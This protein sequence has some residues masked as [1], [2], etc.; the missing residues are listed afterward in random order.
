MLRHDRWVDYAVVCG[1]SLFILIGGLLLATGVK[2]IWRG[3]T[4]R[5]WPTTSGVVA[6]SEAS[7]VEFR[8]EVGGAGFVTTVRHFGQT[9]SSDPSTSQLLQHRYP[10]N[11]TV[12]ISY[13]THSPWISTVEPGF[14]SDAIWLP[15]AGL[16]FA[17]PGIMFIVLWFGLSRESNRGFAL[18]LG[19]FGSIFAGIGLVF[20]IPGLLNLWR[21]YESAHWPRAPGVIVYG[22]VDETQPFSREA[23]SNPE[24]TASSGG[25][26]VYRY[27][28][29]ERTYFSNVRR[30]GQIDDPGMQ[31]DSIYPLGGPLTVAY[32]PSDPAVST[33][34]TGIASESYW[35]PGA[36]SAFFLFGAAVLRFG[37]PALTRGM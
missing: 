16:A 7:D 33:V 3:F 2:N 5:N 22:R 28:V 12:S 35:I 10:V 14:H 29:G 18:G 27:R 25:H 30:F 15:A 31:N 37:I 36:G 34:E 4:S 1:A 9:D 21:A 17:V 23:G 19:L 13:S 26:F 32:S 24:F 20:L 11:S 8:Y 6:A